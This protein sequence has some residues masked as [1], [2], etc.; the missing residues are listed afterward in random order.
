MGS[1]LLGSPFLSRAKRFRMESF[2]PE[3]IYTLSS[4]ISPPL[5]DDVLETLRI[6]SAGV[7]ALAVYALGV[8]W[9]SSE[10]RTPQG[11]IVVFERFSRDHR[12][13]FRDAWRAVRAVAA[14]QVDA[15]LDLVVEYSGEVPQE[16]LEAVPAAADLEFYPTDIVELLAA[17]GMIRLGSDSG[18][19]PVVA[20]PTTSVLARRAGGSLSSLEERLVRDVA[21]AMSLVHQSAVDFRKGSG[22]VEEK[23]FSA[24]LGIALTGT[25]WTFHREKQQGPGRTDLHLR[26][27]GQQGHAVVEVKIWPRNDYRQVHEQVVGYHT[28]DSQALLVVMV[29]P[30]ASVDADTYLAEVLGGRGEV[31]DVPPDMLALIRAPFV[32]PEGGSGVVHH[33]VVRV[34]VR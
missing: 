18:A 23:V 34:P 29:V 32:T 11:L 19:D 22:L 4:Q 8:L 7:P 20:W 33:L 21:A 2:G 16:A 24:T 15:V 5:E 14:A 13:F 31:R 3:D 27:S 6:A 17:A 26:R 12:A 30:S 10:L 9:D 28:A 1:R 25:G